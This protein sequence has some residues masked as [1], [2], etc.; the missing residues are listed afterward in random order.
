MKITKEQL[1][2]IIKEE[3]ENVLEGQSEMFSRYGLQYPGDWGTGRPTPSKPES[4]T[5]PGTDVK[6]DF[7][8]FLRGQNVPSIIRGNDSMRKYAEAFLAS[9]LG[10]EYN[11]EAEDFFKLFKD[12]Y[13]QEDAGIPDAWDLDIWR[14]R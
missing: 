7:K 3:L 5:P 6:E 10:S 11:L 8:K 4:Q 1:K 9:E 14:G 12:D 13:Y 2:Q